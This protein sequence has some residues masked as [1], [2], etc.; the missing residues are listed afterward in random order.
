MLKFSISRFSSKKC[1]IAYKPNEKICS[2]LKHEKAQVTLTIASRPQQANILCR[3]CGQRN[4][5]ELWGY[6]ANG[7]WFCLGPLVTQLVKSFFPG[8]P[9]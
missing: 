9:E 8:V 4:W 3:V 2:H 5:D 1:S 7:P 6:A